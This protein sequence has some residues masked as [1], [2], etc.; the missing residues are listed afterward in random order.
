MSANEWIY[1]SKVVFL[2][3]LWNEWQW[4]MSMTRSGKYEKDGLWSIK[5]MRWTIVDK[6]N[7][8]D[9]GLW[10]QQRWSGFEIM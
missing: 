1:L 5:W 6:M 2:N 3:L 8:L 10:T 7:G 9:F 4:N